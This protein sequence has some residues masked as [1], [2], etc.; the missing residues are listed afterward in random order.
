MEQWGTSSAHKASNSDVVSQ[1][2]SSQG[3]NE[4]VDR[5]HARGRW[6]QI[7]GATPDR[8]DKVL[9]P[10]SILNSAIQEYCEYLASINEH[11]AAQGDPVPAREDCKPLFSIYVRGATKPSCFILWN[12][13][14]LNFLFRTDFFNPRKGTLEFSES[15]LDPGQSRA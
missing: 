14:F 5:T 1:K 2:R 13:I 6:L 15:L 3:V 4:L 9:C 11:R 12:I 10:C 8:F 7:I